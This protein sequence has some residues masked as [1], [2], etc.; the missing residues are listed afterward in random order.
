M[1]I[2]IA[3]ALVLTLPKMLLSFMQLNFL[4]KES[5]KTPYILEK[6]AFIKAAN[7]AL[8]REKIA[9]LNT[10]LD[11]VLVA[12]W[13]LFGLHT[14][15]KFLHFAPLVESVLFVLCFL[16]VQSIVALPLEF[17]Q[18]CVI[19][20]EY[21]FAKGGV[22]L[23]VLDT[24]KSFALLLSVGGVLLFAF[25]WIIMHISFWEFYAFALSAVLI[26]LLNVLYPTLIAPMFNRFTPLENIELRESI[27]SLLECVGFKSDGV[28]V[29]DA[30]KR[31]GRLNAYFAGLGASKRV[32][33]FDTLLQKI[34]KDSILAVLG[35]ELGHFKHYDLY[36]MMGLI[37]VM[38]GILF[39]FVANIPQS[40]FHSVHLEANA[41]TLIVFLLLLSAPFGFYFTLLIN[42]LSC[43]NEFNAD[44]FGAN[45]TSNE[46]LA[47]ALLVLVKE[48]NS[49]PLSHP[50]YMRFYYSHPPLMAR[51]QALN[52]EYLALKERVYEN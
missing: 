33:L 22:K 9:L 17:Y 21:G 30:S 48:N 3:Y 35:H 10:F 12:F 5:Q 36:K 39:F 20:K 4:Q 47:N 27:K 6:D 49:F 42:I 25:S 51:L 18:K 1:E 16:V 2:V 31:D 24:L 38:L 32:I 19:D 46:A 44:R 14:L 26:I 34:P 29:M 15:E 28:F 7:Y 50:L 11:L 37:F 40:I 45:L 41:Q 43:N 23:F 52:C 8:A 13:L